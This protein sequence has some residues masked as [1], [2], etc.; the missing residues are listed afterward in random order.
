[1]YLFTRLVGTVCLGSE[2]IAYLGL[3]RQ[4]WINRLKQLS[5]TS[6][7]ALGED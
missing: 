6:V 7:S 3:A 1:M 5:G 2:V 4:L